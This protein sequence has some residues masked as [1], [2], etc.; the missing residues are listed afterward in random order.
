[1]AADAADLPLA[2]VLVTGA[3][4]FIG[5]A[6]CTYLA[7]AGSP[8]WA[9]LR[10]PADGPWSRVLQHE[11]GEGPLPAGALDGA[12]TVFHLAGRAH[13]LD[14]ALQADAPYQRVN[15]EGT[16]QLARAALAAGV[17]RIVFVSSVK[18]M[19]EGGATVA[20]ER[21][22]ALPVSAYGRSKLA[23][24]QALFEA[25]AGSD[26]EVVVLR[27][28]LVHGPGQRGNLTRMFE[29]VARG[30]FPPLTLGAGRRSMVHVDDVVDAALAVAVTPACAGRVYL[31]SGP[32]DVSSSELHDLMLQALGRRPPRL[33][34][35]V[36]ALWPLAWLGDGLGR[37]LGRRM[38]LD[39]A[40]LQRL[41]GA[42]RYSA[43]RLAA[44]TGFLAR[45][46][47]SVT[48][49]ALA[50]DWQAAAGNAGP[51]RPD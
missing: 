31:L 39:S 15:V 42:A 35:P 5:R 8:P 19:G 28:P 25:C 40:L 26:T 30:R 36:A 12:R 29:A 14:D 46:D 38:P 18:A 4:G 27:P 48:L 7:A 17:R 24:E 16:R 49:A 6:L 3:S 13:A 22:P 20:D 2:P 10:R 21:S 23:A 33:R 1:M 34:L 32:R 43:A 50:R 47:V 37:L 51:E 9:L 41:T 45:R 44:D 11:L